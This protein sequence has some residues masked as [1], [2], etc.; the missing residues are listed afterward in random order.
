MNYRKIISNYRPAILTLTLVTGLSATLSLPALANTDWPTNGWIK[1]S[2]ADAAI[3]PAGMAEAEKFVANKTPSIRSLLIVRGGRL[4]FEKYYNK[5]KATEAQRIASVTKSVTAILTGIAI[6]Q[7]YLSNT[8]LTLAD[9][10]PE[11][12]KDATDRRVATISL[13]Q[14]LTMTAGYKWVDRSQDFWNWRYTKNRLKRGLLLPLAQAPGSS[15]NYATPISHL[16]GGAV[17]RATGHPLLDYANVHL[18]GPMGE[19]VKAWVK[20]PAGLYTGGTGLHLTPRQMAKFG[21]L[22]LNEG[23]WEGRQ[24]VSSNWIKAA[25]R[26][27]LAN[28]G[29]VG[30]G[31]QFWVR[32]IAGC[33]GYMAWGRGG[34]F[35]VVVPDRDLVIAVTSKP[36]VDGPGEAYYLPLFDI[37]TEAS[38][39]QTE[40]R[41]DNSLQ[42]SA[43]DETATA[44]LD[45][46]P[47][48]AKFFADYTGAMTGSDPK[49]LS[50]MYSD[51]YYAD[52]A[53]KAERLR[54]LLRLQSRITAMKIIPESFEETSKGIFYQAHIQS[55]LG[56]FTTKNFIAKE[57]GKWL[58]VGNPDGKPEGITIPDD[59]ARFLDSFVASIGDGEVEEYSGSLAGTYLTNGLTRSDLVAFMAPFLSQLKPADIVV[60]K[61]QRDGDRATIEGILIS[62]SYGLLPLNPLYG[63]L[64]RVDGKWLWNGNQ[65]P[66]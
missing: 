63:S 5:A 4:V 9:L 40:C 64:I 50:A 11:F 16:I 24:L 27:H 51:R 39:G 66:E 53:N 35:I 46:P 18:F 57:G 33:A 14:L 45:I 8:E 2:L 31:Y 38:G 36:R 6:D 23:R 3:D 12:I 25:T 58:L 65:L 26:N 21:Y 19:T 30:Y 41:R 52:G 42:P 61:F 1:A 20:D 43:I 34:Q 28:P 55:S 62:R 29:S 49:A 56:N 32:N 10:Y 54:G 17:S 44:P 37:I 13:H 60:S 59:V 7:G 48:L 47:S 15:F 22:L